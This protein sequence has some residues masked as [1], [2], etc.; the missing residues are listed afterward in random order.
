MCT[1]LLPLRANPTAVNKYIN[2][3]ISN[4]DKISP[5]LD[6]IQRWLNSIPILTS[7]SLTSILIV[8]Y[9]PSVCLHHYRTICKEVTKWTYLI[10]VLHCSY[11][12]HHLFQIKPEIKNVKLRICHAN[13]IRKYKNIS[14]MQLLFNVGG[15]LLLRR[16]QCILTIN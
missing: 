13:L 10:V 6:I 1:I 11:P 5:S 8:P 12:L 14:H 2:I 4:Q 7:H 15:T 9:C 3:N 16:K